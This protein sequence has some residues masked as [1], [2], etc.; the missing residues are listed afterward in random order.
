M[1]VGGLLSR[2]VGL[3][4]ATLAAGRVRFMVKIK[5]RTHAPCFGIFTHDG[6][7]LLDKLPPPAPCVVAYL[8]RRAA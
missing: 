6:G 4:V 8:L 7:R 3:M 2:R 5:T 1:V